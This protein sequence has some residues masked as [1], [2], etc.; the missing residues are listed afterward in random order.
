M[1]TNKNLIKPSVL[2]IPKINFKSTLNNNNSIKKQ[3]KTKI[4]EDLIVNLINIYKLNSTDIECLKIFL[5]VCKDY[6]LIKLN[7]YNNFR[8]EDVIK[9]LFSKFNKKISNYEKDKILKY[10]KFENKQQEEEKEEEQQEEQHEED[11]DEE[12]NKFNYNMERLNNNI[13][14]SLLGN[15][16]IRNDKID[17]KKVQKDNSI[18]KKSNKSGN[19]LFFEEEYL[20]EDEKN[21]QYDAEFVDIEL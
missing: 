16:I 6:D 12:F 15:N 17:F 19:N 13:V 20:D 11:D 7:I 14:F 18:I 5:K 21:F 8:F 3:N 9:L 10:L 1:S 4:E 2:K